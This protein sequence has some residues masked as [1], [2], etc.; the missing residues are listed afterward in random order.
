MQLLQRDR[1]L[2][3]VTQDVKRRQDVG[4]LHHLSKR[5]P[6]QHLGTEDVPRLFGQ[7]SNVNQYLEQVKRGF[8]FQ[9]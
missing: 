6:L 4:P 1:D 8:Y 5:A 3:V 9:C 2:Q 7:E